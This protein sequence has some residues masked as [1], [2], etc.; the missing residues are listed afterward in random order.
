MTAQKIVVKLIKLKLFGTNLEKVKLKNLFKKNAG[1]SFIQTH[2]VY[3]GTCSQSSR[4]LESVPG[5]PELS[6]CLMAASECSKV[7]LP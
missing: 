4:K 1:F 2:T 5:K 3:I 7:Q 6:C